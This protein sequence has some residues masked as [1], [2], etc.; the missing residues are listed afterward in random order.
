MKE[1]ELKTLGVKPLRAY[2]LVSILN[3]GL[4]SASDIND[5]SSL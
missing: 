3:S 1:L 2:D 4:H 5:M